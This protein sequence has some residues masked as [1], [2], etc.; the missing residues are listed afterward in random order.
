MSV[1]AKLVC[2]SLREKS[3]DQE[4]IALCSP[5]ILVFLHNNITLIKV[6][7]SKVRLLVQIQ[8]VSL[9]MWSK[10]LR[11]CTL[12]VTSLSFK[13]MYIVID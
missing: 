3:L 1:E 12:Y 13:G 4:N 11:T 6:C 8:H 7:E 5:L 10:V 9:K 2:L